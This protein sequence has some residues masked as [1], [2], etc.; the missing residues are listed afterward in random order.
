MSTLFSP[1]TYPHVCRS[2]YESSENQDNAKLA[3]AKAEPY[4]SLFVLGSDIAVVTPPK[5]FFIVDLTLPA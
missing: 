4:V 5:S 1:G 3:G 2:T